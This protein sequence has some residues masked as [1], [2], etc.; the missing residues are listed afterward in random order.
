MRRKHR[1]WLA[2]AA[3]ATLTCCGCAGILA[4]TTRDD[5]QI[6]RVRLGTTDK[7][8]SIDRTYKKQDESCIMLKKEATF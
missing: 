7:W 5:G 8:S 4:E 6:E 3:W 1:V 2:V